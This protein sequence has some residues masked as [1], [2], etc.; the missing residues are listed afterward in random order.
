MGKH[1]Q[2]KKSSPVY[3]GDIKAVANEIE[4]NI[5]N[6]LEIR[7]RQYHISDPELS[8]QELSSLR[9]KIVRKLIEQLDVSCL[10]R[11]D[12]LAYKRMLD[13]MVWFHTKPLEDHRA[14]EP[15]T[16]YEP[17]RY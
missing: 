9:T 7:R 12:V 16:D 3:C 13:D 6:Q 8:E 1:Q 2:C 10:D 17:R 4:V 5:F 14:I 11:H 15:K